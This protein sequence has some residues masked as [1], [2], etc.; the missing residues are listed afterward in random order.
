MDFK[1]WNLSSILSTLCHLQFILCRNVIVFIRRAGYL[2]KPALT[3][4]SSG[5]QSAGV[6]VPFC[7]VC[8]RD[9]QWHPQKRSQYLDERKGNKIRTCEVK[10]GKRLSLSGLW[11]F[12]TPWTIA[13]QAPLSMEFFRQ[14]YWNG[15]PSPPPGDLPDPGI[16]SKSPMLQADSLLSESL[17]KPRKMC[18]G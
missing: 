13:R 17:R 1:K 3:S 8:P 18:D 14:K 11:F 6:A 7:S 15:Y 16:K 4:I 5:N 9:T 12:A 10:K 2:G